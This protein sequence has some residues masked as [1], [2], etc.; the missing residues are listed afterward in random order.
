[1]K[2][3]NIVSTALAAIVLLAVLALKSKWN[4]TTGLT[5]AANSAEE[6]ILT[7]A[8]MGGQIP[9]INGYEPLKVFRLGE[10]RAGL[11]RAKPAPLVFAPGRFVIYDQS[12]QPVYKLDT[13]EGSKD[14][15]S[16][17]YDFNGRKGLP[18]PSIR[19]RPTYTRDLTGKGV[20]DVILGQYSG[21]SHCCTIVT[22]LELDK[23]AVISIGR[24]EGLDGMPF[25]GLEVRKLNKGAEFQCI[26]HRPYP[27]ACGNHFDAPDVLAVYNFDGK[28]F[29]DET[30][31]FG[32]YLQDVLRQDLAKWKEEKNRTM[33]LLQTVSVD[34]AVVGQKDVAKQFFAVNLDPLIAKLQGSKVDA[35]AC[36]DTL[37]S[38]VDRVPSAETRTQ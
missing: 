27:T 15:W 37:Q 5:E 11:Y 34:Y 4:P 8:G 3:E 26:A 20:P 1:M 22:I 2:G 18:G 38:L 29:E 21:G 10:Y 32:D 30:R 14:T 35:H 9:E 33:E 19:G 25:E 28:H 7:R 23:D 16:T 6:F 31:D 24:I 13:L 12:D 36:L 17:L